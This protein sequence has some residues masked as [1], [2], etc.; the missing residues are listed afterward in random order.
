MPPGWLPHL[1][2]AHSTLATSGPG[3]LGSLASGSPGR[4]LDLLFGAVL[5]F[6]PGPPVVRTCHNCA[7]FRLPQYY[8][9]ERV[10]A[11]GRWPPGPHS[12]AALP[13]SHHR[14]WAAAAGD[15]HLVGATH[16]RVVTS[17]S[18]YPDVG[19]RA[20]VVAGE[21]APARPVG[22]ACGVGGGEWGGLAAAAGCGCG[23]GGGLAGGR[24]ATL[25][26]Y[27]GVRSSPA[28]PGQGR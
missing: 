5:P 17:A 1:V 11:R 23:G 16:G 26:T 24:R 19:R 6:S 10:A 28:Q 7:P 9:S 18:R 25:A 13:G 22:T 8:P 15:D 3:R 2:V 14:G 4:A 27:I 20:R 21:E 12:F